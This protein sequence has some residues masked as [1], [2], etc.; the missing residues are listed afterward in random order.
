MRNAP[1]TQKLLRDGLEQ[2]LLGLNSPEVS[3]I[4]ARLVAQYVQGLL[5]VKA[6]QPCLEVYVQPA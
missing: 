4:V 6:L 5:A 1:K 2:C 3:G